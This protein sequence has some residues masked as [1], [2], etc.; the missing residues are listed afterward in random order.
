M[1]ATSFV[2]AYLLLLLLLQL[3]SSQSSFSYLMMSHTA[4]SN[5]SRGRYDLVEFLLV[6]FHDQS[7]TIMCREEHM[8]V[9]SELMP[10]DPIDHRCQLYSQLMRLPVEDSWTIL[11]AHCP[12]ACSHNA[13]DC[14]F[15][16][17]PH[18]PQAFER[19]E[20]RLTGLIIIFPR[21]VAIAGHPEF[22]SQSSYS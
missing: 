17:T 4:R 8:P 2:P 21:I 19:K 3:P 22:C 16:A 18:S 5:F 10:L 7:D 9:S 14:I 20:Q 12:L 15:L 1:S 11:I 13:G 6:F